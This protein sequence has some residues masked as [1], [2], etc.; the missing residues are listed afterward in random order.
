MGLCLSMPHAH[1]TCNVLT[2]SKLLLGCVKLSISLSEIELAGDG[3][4]QQFLVRR[5]IAFQKVKNIL[6]TPTRLDFANLLP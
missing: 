6:N 3:L 2:D 5:N 1:Q 4:F